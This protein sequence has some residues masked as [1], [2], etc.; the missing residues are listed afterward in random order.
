VDALPHLRLQ[1]LQTTS[2]GSIRWRKLPLVAAVLFAAAGVWRAIMA[3]RHYQQSLTIADD[4]S[5]RELEQVS[6]L[7][8]GGIAILLW[9]HAV[10]LLWLARNP[11]TFRWPL[12]VGVA[13]LCGT[14]LSGA[15][16]QWP[17]L[18][19][20][21]GYALSIV[22]GAA[23]VSRFTTFSWVSLYAGALVGGTIAWYAAGPAPDAFAGLFVVMPCVA[24]ALLGA[25][26]GRLV[27]RRVPA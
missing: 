8:E 25:A 23:I 4:P 12:A 1:S 11:C 16:L 27:T 13:L 20:P 6:A 5:M 21:I 18:A 2:H 14:A 19:S 10:A 22:I 15:L 24:Y 17:P 3:V 26:L 7:F 9:A